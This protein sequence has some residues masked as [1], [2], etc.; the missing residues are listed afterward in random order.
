MQSPADSRELFAGSEFDHWAWVEAYLM[1]PE[2]YLI[3]HYLSTQGRTL[4]AGVGG[5]RILQ[6]MTRLG[7]S[8]LSGFDNVPE[9]IDAAR[10]RDPSRKIA[11]CVADARQ[12]PHS[13]EEFDQVIYLG[14]VTSFISEAE[15]RRKVAAEAYR[16]LK[17]GGTALFSFLCYEVRLQILRYKA[18]IS[19]I[20][21]L[22]R[23]TGRHESSQLLPWLLRGGKFNLSALLDRP[24]YVYW[25]RIEEA[26]ELLTSTGFSIVAI[27]TARQLE[28]GKMCESIE[29]VKR[30]HLGGMLYVACRK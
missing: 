5:G 22:R 13:S 15:G 10:E 8:D 29:E 2:R 16:V 3:E 11:L 21:C 9:M 6:A 12:L 25:F 7:F 1:T 24:P 28:E 27:A 14:Q 30:K 26:V 20:A 17:E 18:I 23:L 19:Y 4:E